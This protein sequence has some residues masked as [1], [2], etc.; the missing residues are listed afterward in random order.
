MTSTGELNWEDIRRYHRLLFALYDLGNVPKEKQI[1]KIASKKVL[2]PY[3]SKIRKG[4]PKQS[5]VLRASLRV[6]L[7]SKKAKSLGA[8][9][10]LA[11]VDWGKYN[12][13]HYRYRRMQKHGIVRKWKAFYGRFVELG[14][15]K[16][17][18][19]HFIGK[20][21]R[22]NRHQILIAFEKEILNLVRKAVK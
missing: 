18:A 5:G 3:V 6:T 12:K 9:V 14:T 4:T 20:V 15:E 1:I 19:Q 22:A 8:K 10:S 21:M 2:R 16:Q 11:K 13:Y 17:L 7:L